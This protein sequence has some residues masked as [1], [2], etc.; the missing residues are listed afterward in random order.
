MNKESNLWGIHA[1]R[2]GGAESIF[3]N[4]HCVALGWEEVGDL[5]ELSADR[6]AFKK[7]IAEVYPDKNGGSV[8]NNAGQLFRFTHEMKIG[9]HVV[10]SSRSDARIHFGRVEGDY[11]HHAKE[12]GYRHRRAVKWIRSEPRTLFS[13]GALYEIGSAITFFQV[14]NYADEFF[15][16]FEGTA[17]SKAIVETD[18]PTVAIVADDIE[19]NTRTFILKRLSQEVK[20]H[21]FEHFVAHLLQ[22]MGYRTRVTKEGTDGGIDIVAHRD[23]L[24]FEPPIVKVQVKSTSGPIGGPVVS[25]LIG[26]LGAGEFGLV[27][28]LGAFTSQAIQFAKSNSRVRLI[29]GND[30][31]DLILGH[32]ERF[33]ARYKGLLPLRKVYVPVSIEGENG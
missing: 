16:R 23:E 30:L 5:S 33:D 14:R 3:L 4:E 32:Y 6:E 19:D 27:V 29:G 31:V 20:G 28:T 9:D 26:Q 17:K 1:G 18:D 22:L 8:A 10:Y 24:G 21:P 15:A 7:R 13:Q 11:R 12:K 2:F 25:A